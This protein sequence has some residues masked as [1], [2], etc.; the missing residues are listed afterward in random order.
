MLEADITTIE[1]LKDLILS[2]PI[3]PTPICRNLEYIFDWKFF[4]EPCLTTPP[5]KYHSHYNSFMLRT[6]MRDGVKLVV[7]RAKKLPQ[8]TQ[9]V[10]KAGIRLVKPGIVFSPVGCA[11]FRVERINFDEIIRGLMIYLSKQPNHERIKVLKSWDALRERIESS[12]RRRD[13]YP[14][15]KLLDLPKQQYEILQVPD[16]L[17]DGDDS[18]KELEGD[19]YSEEIRD[20]DLDSEIAVGLDV[21]VYTLEKEGRPWVGRVVEILTDQRFII[22]WF[23]RRTTRSKKFEA[24]YND[25]GTRS[26]SEM[27]NSSVMVRQMSENR[28]ETSFTLSSYWLEDIRREYELHDSQ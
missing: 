17:E 10:P 18:D 22:H 3:K 9:L 27:E 11:E 24:M 21:C 4:I 16:Y 5:L 8:D 1:V 19:F 14:K 7:F 20:G 6:E 13:S 25:N 26:V 12:P 28:T 2:A 23:S 15:M